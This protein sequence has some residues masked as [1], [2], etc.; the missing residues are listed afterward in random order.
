MIYFGKGVPSSSFSNDK[1]N[2]LLTLLKIE[3]IRY[4]KMSALACVAISDLYLFHD[5][6]LLN[7]V[8]NC[9]NKLSTSSSDKVTTGTYNFVSVIL[10]LVH[11]GQTISVNLRAASESEFL[12]TLLFI[13]QFLDQV[14]V[15]FISQLI[16]GISSVLKKLLKHF[17]GR[18]ISTFFFYVVTF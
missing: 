14:K 4:I 16:S 11:I 18:A 15:R 8:F 6:V 9:C 13:T 17:N 12:L 3:S 1:T 10:N 7:A 2:N 5:I